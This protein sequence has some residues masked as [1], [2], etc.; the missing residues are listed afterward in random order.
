MRT[1][2][3]DEEHSNYADLFTQYG[4]VDCISIPSIPQIESYDLICYVGGND[5]DP[6]LYGH[7]K[8]Y[9]THCNLALDAPNELA[10]MVATRKNIPVVGICK[11]AQQVFVFNGGTLFQHVTN[12]CETHNAFTT[13]PLFK[14]IQITSSHHQMMDLE[15][16]NPSRYEL[17]SWCKA[18]STRYEREAICNTKPLDK[19][20]EVVFFPKTKQL[21][22][23]YHPEWMSVDS[24][25][26]K[27]FDKLVQEKLLSGV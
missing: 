12:H 13:D 2:V 4:E 7:K 10:H 23:Q 19:E 17:L 1:L 20:P 18:R 21:A 6:S 25:G 5:V 11:G 14:E 15:S 22:V 27:Y 9:M 24:P 16:L 8:N 26:A 3:I